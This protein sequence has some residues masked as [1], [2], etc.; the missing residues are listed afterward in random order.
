MEIASK[1]NN[2]S[3]TSTNSCMWFL[4]SYHETNRMGST[5]LATGWLNKIRKEQ[6]FKQRINYDFL[7]VLC[8]DWS[9]NGLVEIY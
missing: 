9:L 8:T 6:I 5:Y 2:F 4:S 7:T 3:Y 1:V